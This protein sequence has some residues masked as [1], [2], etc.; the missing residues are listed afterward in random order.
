MQLQELTR[1]ARFCRCR[2]GSG[3]GRLKLEADNQKAKAVIDQ[4]SKDTIGW[5]LLAWGL[6]ITVVI[7]A[8]VMLARYQ[9]MNPTRQDFS[10][11]IFLEMITIFVLTASVLILGLAGKLQTEG[12]AALIGGISGYVLG[13]SKDGSAPNR[14]QAE[15]R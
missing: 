1:T 13:K 2:N 12:L 5:T 3:E 7:A 15:T 14:P 9:S 11:P 6:I 10:Y 4:V 8:I